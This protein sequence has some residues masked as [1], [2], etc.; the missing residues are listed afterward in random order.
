MLTDN[1]PAPALAKLL[2][3]DEAVEHLT[4]HVAKTQDGIVSARARLT[5]GFHKQAEYDDLTESLRQLIADKPVLEQK[6]RVAQTVLSNAK[7]WLERLP[8]DTQLEIVEVK[9]DGDLEEVRERIN[10]LEAEL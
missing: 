6:L 8:E 3:L 2:S 10:T 1:I 5:G 9:A 4:Q 7:A